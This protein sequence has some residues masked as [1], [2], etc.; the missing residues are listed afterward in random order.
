[1]TIAVTCCLSARPLPV[2]AAL[3]SLGVC[4]ATGMPRPRRH[5]HGDARSLSGLHHRAHVVLAEDPL[6]RDRVGMVPPDPGKEFALEGQQSV[7]DRGRRCAAQD[8]H[9]DEPQPASR[10]AVDDAEAA[11]GEARIDTEYPHA[12]T[13]ADRS[14]CRS[15]RPEP[16]TIAPGRPKRTY[17]RPAEPTGGAAAE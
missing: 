1:M 6:D 10:F 16:L 7:L 2:T 14:A 12:A 5:Q 17:V 13:S 8:T 3:T 15:R 4:R 11:S 9:F